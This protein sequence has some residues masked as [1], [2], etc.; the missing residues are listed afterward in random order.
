MS[1]FK[2][3]AYIAGP[4]RGLGRERA[5]GVRSEAERFLGYR[6]YTTFNPAGAWY[7]DP[8]EV[9][10]ELALQSINDHIISISSLFVAIMLQGVESVGTEH[11]LMVALR[12]GKPVMILLQHADGI[13]EFVAT[14]SRLVGESRAGV[15]NEVHFYSI[16][17][18]TGSYT[19]LYIV[20][21]EPVL[22]IEEVEEVA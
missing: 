3:I 17:P 5:I 4:V 9:R 16:N 20:Q 6:G 15:S 2:G 7:G 12:S 8:G 14:V 1:N 11:E 22:E 21:Y 10:S 18:D 19:P 13:S